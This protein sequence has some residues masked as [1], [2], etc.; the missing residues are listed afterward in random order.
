MTEM[1]Q[2]IPG[3]PPEAPGKPILPTEKQGY[4][5]PAGLQQGLDESTGVGHV[6]EAG[7]G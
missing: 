3:P 2:E 6:W 5:L 4:L 7:A 1:P